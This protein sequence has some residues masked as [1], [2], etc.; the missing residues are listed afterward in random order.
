MVS[1]EFIAPFTTRVGISYALMNT[2]AVE[3]L[4]LK[5][6]QKEHSKASW[7][8]SP[9]IKLGLVSNLYRGYAILLL[10]FTWVLGPWQIQQMQNAWGGLSYNPTFE[11]WYLTALTI[12]AVT[13]VGYP[14]AIFLRVGRK[15]QQ[16]E[17]VSALKWFGV[18]WIGITLTLVIFYG[19]LRT[20][21][22]EI[23]EL[24]HLF[25]IVFFCVIAYGFKK[26]VSMES[27][28]KRLHTIS[29]SSRST[30]LIKSVEAFS[31]AL[32]LTR[33]QVVRKNILLEFDPTSDYERVVEDFV[34]ETLANADPAA[35]FTSKGGTIHSAL[36]NM[37]DVSF[38]LFT[39]RVSNPQADLSENK[40]LL[41]TNNSS[42]LLDALNK[43]LKAYPERNPSVVFDNLSSLILFI[44]FD[45]TYSFLRYALEL[46]VLE[47]GT[48]L[49]LFNPRAHDIKVASA[50]RSLFSDQITYRKEGLRVVRT[51]E[52]PLKS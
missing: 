10:F 38:L 45:K 13:F 8:L 50:L 29:D 11:P 28:F 6:N 30:G 34:D 4:A 49:F 51:S 47:N 25:T 42:L 24:G 35:V 5:L 7:K 36:G 46:L 37:S 23:V 12:L 31:K 15:Y 52:P 22:I 26:A 44:G 48:S 2:I 41:P 17:V 14:C 27:I 18:G 33:E 19:I 9:S 1:P 16:P 32:G 20:L 43:V 3:H 21:N 40:I 39:Q